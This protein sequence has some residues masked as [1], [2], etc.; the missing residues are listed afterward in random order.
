[1]LPDQPGSGLG[2]GPGLG[3]E[4][5]PLKHLTNKSL[6]TSVGKISE[7]DTFLAENYARL[8]DFFKQAVW[9][10]TASISLQSS[11]FG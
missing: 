10:L 7:Y 5:F 4:G 1:M 6:F 2:W 11:V 3:W 8:H 9:C